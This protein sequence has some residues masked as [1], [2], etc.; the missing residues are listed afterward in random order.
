MVMSYRL[1]PVLAFA[2]GTACAAR[3]TAS[4]DVR[5]ADDTPISFITEDGVPPDNECR[6]PLVD[7]R[8][9]TRLR[10]VRSTAIG[11]LNRGDYQ[12]PRGRYGV[13]DGELL[14]IDCETGQAIGI[15]R[16]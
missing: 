16:S 2:F 14:R 9:Q 7:P 11:S 10:L 12:V 6:S 4:S 1:V 8:D 13:A 15:V 5:P 3:G